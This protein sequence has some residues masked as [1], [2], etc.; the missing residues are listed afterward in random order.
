LRRRQGFAN[1]S[2]N[3][4]TAGAALT[5]FV[6][7][8]S[9]G[10]IQKYL[11]TAAAFAYFTAGFIALIGFSSRHWP[12]FS[13]RADT[14]R[15]WFSS[16]TALLFGALAIVFLIGYPLVNTHAASSVSPAAAMSGGSDRDESLRLGVSELLAG[17]Y[18]YYQMTPLRNFVT[19]LP[20]SL[21]L[22]V[23][24]AILGDPVW[25]NLFWFAGF[26]ALTAYVLGRNRVAL[27]LIVLTVF[28]CPAVLQDFVTGGDLD[29]N[30]ITLLVGMVLIVTFAS[31]QSIAPWKKFAVAAFT[32]LA[33]SSRLNY[34]LLLAP[35]FAAVA[36]RASL[37]DAVAT[38]IVIGVSFGAVT[39]PFYIHDPSGFAP[40]Y[41]HNK[42]AQFDGEVHH[43]RI[44]FPV[45]SLLF[46][47]MV[48]MYPGNRA[49]AGWLIQ[50]GVVLT[51]PVIF[52]VALATTRAGALNFVFAD[53]AL[54]AAFFGSLGV[55]LKAFE[56]DAA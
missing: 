23:P 10:L 27:F 55:G 12:A 42:F 5:W 22:A 28:G 51:L 35:L 46:S 41:L 17:R 26:F 2:P 24:F 11:G 8:P 53:Y 29:V 25:Q 33:L 6:L 45:L 13:R 49:V 39:L 48:A 15:R 32:G 50:S 20:G 14:E 43:G 7:F 52:L 16:T 9:L 36:R 21:F 40:L 56:H 3:A 18:P 38:M 19:Q 34:V 30:A 37:T 44:L 1:I 54:P 4:L 47:T 31:D